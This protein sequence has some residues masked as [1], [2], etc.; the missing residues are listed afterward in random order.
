[1]SPRL[2]L[3]LHTVIIALVVFFVYLLRKKKLDLKY[4]LV[5]IACLLVMAVLVIFPGA[6]QS[7]AALL[8]IQT[9]MYTLFFVSIAVLGCICLS[10][11]V[12]VS[13]LSD[14]LRT[15]TQNLAI[16]EKENEK[17]S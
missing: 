6:L 4:S 7:M 11:T 9:P 14:R 5:W 17:S 2:Q 16:K 13:R 10:L 1:M 8:S 3:L 12:V 15:L